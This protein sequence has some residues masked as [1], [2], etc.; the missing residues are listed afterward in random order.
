MDREEALGPLGTVSPQ[1]E[2]YGRRQELD[3]V[4]HGFKIP[5][6]RRQRPVTSVSSQP[7]WS[8]QQF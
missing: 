2:V 6:L 8:A 7:A 1:E 5:A 4:V 3:I